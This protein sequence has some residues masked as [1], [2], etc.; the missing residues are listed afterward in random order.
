[1]KK[2]KTSV[3]TILIVA[4]IIAS[5]FI[6]FTSNNWIYFCFAFIFITIVCYF[7]YRIEIKPIIDKLAF[8][9]KNKDYSDAI[10]FLLEK[11]DNCY[12][13]STKQ[14]C[15]TY[16]IIVYMN[17]DQV[18]DAITLLKSNPKLKKAN[19]LL[20]INFILAVADGNHMWI[21]FYAN[22]IL[23]LK[24]KTYD[25][26]K[27]NVK[28]ILKMINTN[29]FDEELYE[30]TN[31]PLVKRICLKIKGEDVILIPNEIKKDKYQHT[32][33]TVLSIKRK[34]INI[35]LNIFTCLSIYFALMFIALLQNKA[36]TNTM[37]EMS[38]LFLGSLWIFFIFLPI[39]L[40]NLFNGLDLK[41]KNLKCKSNMILGSVFSVILFLFGMA[42]FIFIGMY[43]RDKTYLYE[44]EEKINIDF[45]DD[46]EIIIENNTGGIQETANNTISKY[47]ALVFVS[48][49]KVRNFDENL[50]KNELHNTEL[51]PSLYVLSIADFEQQLVYCFDTTEYNPNSY[52]SNYDYIVIGYDYDT[53]SF[54]MYEF[55]VE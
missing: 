20:Y 36:K 29:Q 13:I 34:L 14:T 37:F 45:P 53:N 19:L 3:A 28:K 40:L 42:Y 51:L 16:L 17:N 39:P 4:V 50:W 32:K 12:F 9:L 11:K 27:N 43:S 18:L 15:I 2:Y 52:S 31:I 22:K 7:G 35:I 25:I 8:Y 48:G 26:Q 49:D 33:V 5:L 41:N 21:S 54:L 46:F 47:G 24:N 55:N 6:S 23:S 44:L 30:N 1:M 38:Y 10:N